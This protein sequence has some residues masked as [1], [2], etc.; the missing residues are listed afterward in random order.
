MR[1][2]MVLAGYLSQV[3]EMSGLFYEG[4]H[5]FRPRYSCESQV[6]TV[7]Y[8][9]AHSLDEEVRTE[10]IITYFSKAFDLVPHERL[11][12]EIVAN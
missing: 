2:S 12:T 8:D 4:Q 10:A 9:K 11:L 5:G 1:V 6:V 7:C 3:L